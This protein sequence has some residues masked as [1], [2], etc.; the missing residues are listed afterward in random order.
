MQ[1][2]SD[3]KSFYGF[4]A[5]VFTGLVLFSCKTKPGN[6]QK[7]TAIPLREMKKNEA[8]FEVTGYPLPTSFY[9]T[10][11]LEEAKAPY[12]FSISNSVDN[13]DHY[14]SHREKAL[15]LG[16][17]GADLCYAV[18]YM[19]AQQNLDH[20]NTSK[21][22]QDEINILTTYH[23]SCCQRVEDNLNNEDSLITIISDSF[24]DTYD[25]LTRN[26]KDRTAIL[27]MTGS[28]IEGIYI[29]TQIGLTAGDNRKILDIVQEQRTS[30]SKL[31]EVMEPVREDE[32]VVDIYHALTELK[33]LF[34]NDEENITQK[35]F[36]KILEAVRSLRY[37]II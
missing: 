26:Q 35:Q 34:G 14:F 30:L 10:S 15:N 19:K 6:Q 1:L 2:T 25:Y 17:F 7:G 29:A 4:L 12:I 22:L 28:W 31:L 21:R 36:E 18:T 5:I 20:R 32:E 3:H 27:V 16:V 37:K 8:V 23:K 24:Y 11:M 13:V 9:I 33:K